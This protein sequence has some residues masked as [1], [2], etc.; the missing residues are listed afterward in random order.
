MSWQARRRPPARWPFRLAHRLPTVVL[1]QPWAIFIKG[2]CVLSGLTTFLGPAPGSIE[3][4]LPVPVVYVWSATLV[5][6]A[7]AGLYGM[8]RPAAWLVEVAGL[9]WLGTAALVY[10][11]TVLV[12]FRLDGAVP[13]SILVAFGLAALTRA[14]AVHVSYAIASAAVDAADPQAALS[15][16]RRRP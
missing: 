15:R 5:L 6:G 8:L 11:L 9:I 1:D 2:L 13:A 4:T 7:T 3:S 16:R 14:L 10:G 12:Q